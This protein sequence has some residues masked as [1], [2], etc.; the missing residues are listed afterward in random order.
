[1]VLGRG[2]RDEG[3]EGE[4]EGEGGQPQ[5]VN[6]VRLLKVATQPDASQVAE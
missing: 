4:E 5:A 1:M 6:A 2:C 3:D